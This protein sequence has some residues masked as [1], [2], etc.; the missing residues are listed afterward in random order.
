MTNRRNVRKGMKEQQ[1]RAASYPNGQKANDY[2]NHTQEN[3]G[4]G[5]IPPRGNVG[6]SRRV[7]RSPRAR[8]ISEA[9]QWYRKVQSKQ[10]NILPRVG[11]GGAQTLVTE[12]SQERSTIQEEKQTVQGKP[13]H[14]R[15]I[16]EGQKEQ[17][18]SPVLVHC[19]GRKSSRPC[20]C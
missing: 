1:P 15:N 2:S 13:W 8:R 18:A 3:A 10:K 19:P 14:R 16:S 11:A 12:P 20:L 7:Q 17:Q 6:S 5:H 4:R 9:R